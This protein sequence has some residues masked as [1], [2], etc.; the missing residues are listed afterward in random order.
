MGR[1]ASART[2]ME[3]KSPAPDRPQLSVEELHQLRWLLGG[4]LALISAWSVFYFDIQAWTLMA[5][6]TAATVAGW[7]WPQLPAKVPKFVHTFAFL[8][9]VAFFL[10][11]LWFTGDTLPAIV[12]LDMMLL[13]YR[14]I[15]YRRR[16]E[17]LQIIVM[18]LFLIVVAGVLTVSMIFALQLLVFAACSL[19]LLLVLT[20]LHSME[21]GAPPGEGEGGAP[22]W[23][24]VKWR[25]LFSRLRRVMDW[26]VV[27]LG[28][29]LFVGVVGVSAALFVLI[30]R[31]QLENSLFLERFIVR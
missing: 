5:V 26:R 23:A 12:R 6:I 7:V 18:G 1:G 20:L 10:G 17:D 30:P 15:S 8:L 24:E 3:K 31:F 28:G 22:R 25:R 21:L 14:G 29:L 4:M 9:I 16:R 2:L 27:T 13:L 19:A 11:D